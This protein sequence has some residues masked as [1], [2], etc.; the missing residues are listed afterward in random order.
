MS[1]A[2]ETGNGKRWK[3]VVDVWISFYFLGLQEGGEGGTTTISEQN[4]ER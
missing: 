4:R 3:T 2:R 1:E